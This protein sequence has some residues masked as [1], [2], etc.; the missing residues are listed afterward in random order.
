MECIDLELLYF[1][2]CSFNEIVK[3]DK[4]NLTNDIA[5]GK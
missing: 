2:F 1:A 4:S 5:R 3:S